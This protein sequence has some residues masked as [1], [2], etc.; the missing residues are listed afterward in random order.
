[1]Q[2]YESP[3]IHFEKLVFFEKIAA[4]CWGFSGFFYDSTIDT[5]MDQII[6]DNDGECTISADAVKKELKRIGVFS[7]YPADEINKDNVRNG[8]ILPNISW[9]SSGI[10]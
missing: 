8:T 4:N 3:K 2:K 7:S 5:P 1:M 10:K 6:S 9:T